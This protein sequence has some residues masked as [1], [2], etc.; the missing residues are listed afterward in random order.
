MERAV[1]L[2]A[3]RG[4]YSLPVDG[5][6]PESLR[7]AI[8][9]ALLIPGE[10]GY[11]WGTPDNPLLRRVRASW[12]DAIRAVALQAIGPNSGILSYHGRS[13]NE[14]RGGREGSNEQ[15]CHFAFPFLEGKL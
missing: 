10:R 11:F 12:F 2:S 8:E 9:H 1:D 13:A 14:N 7:G 3:D 6:H 5:K 15:F 4:A